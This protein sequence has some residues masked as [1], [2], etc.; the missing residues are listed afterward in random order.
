MED[1]K[2]ASEL[3]A[4][5]HNLQGPDRKSFQELFLKHHKAMSEIQ[6]MEQEIAHLQSQTR[7]LSLEMEEVVAQAKSK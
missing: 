6:H 5:A 7:R 2:L 1:P 3:K 4:N